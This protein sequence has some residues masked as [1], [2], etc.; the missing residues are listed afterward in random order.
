[1]HAPTLHSSR[2]LE[3]DPLW[4]K[5][6]IFYEVMVRS[7]ADSNGDGS[8]DLQGLISKLDYLQ[9]LGVDALWLPP[10]FVSPLKDGGYD[11]ADY[12]AVLPDFGSLDDFREL[13]TQAHSRNMRVVIDLVLNHTSDAHPWFQE[14][15]RDPGGPFGDFYVWS[16][17]NDRYPNIR[18][19]FTDTEKSNWAFDTERRQFYFHRFFSHQPD[20]NY[21]NPA[22]H[23]A[24]FDVVRFW[25]E[26]GIDGFR[27][28]AIPY[29]YQSDDGTGEG[30]PPTHS[31]IGRLRSLIDRDYPGRIMIAEANQWPAETA[32]FFGTEDEPECHMA[33]D[34]PVMPRIF[35]SLRSQSATELRRVL[36][37]QTDIP[38]HAGWGVF[39]RNH[40]ELSLEMVSEEYRQAMYGW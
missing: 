27:L 23:E 3:P 5:Q 13:V 1:M 26:M 35:Y 21:E 4:H 32:A 18:I 34:F 11:V 30:E 20:L 33:F 2:G 40:D 19:I 31:F 10:F 9:W 39:L 29:L 6:A 37:E 15:R 24:M 14:S 16:D 22:V 25:L 12:R 17:V 28:D 8:G 36:S 38:R 7:F